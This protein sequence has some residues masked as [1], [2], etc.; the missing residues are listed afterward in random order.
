[1]D[2][3]QRA[4]LAKVATVPWPRNE[5]SP[6]A[7]VKSTSYAENSIAL[8]A[9]QAMGAQEALLANTQG[10]LCEGTSSNVFLVLNGA[11]CTPPLSS[12]CLAGVTRH[13]VLQ[14]AQE[15]GLTVQQ[16]PLP[17]Q[18]IYLASEAFL[19]STYREVQAIA[20][21]DAQVLPQA[22]GPVTQALQAAFHKLCT[23]HD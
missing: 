20:Q 10:D 19:T 8:A 3:P 2:L 6:L 1:M 23:A 22:P 15:M 7:E 14:L 21:V 11:L 16:E 17:F 18:S 4:A 12:G 9:A 5:R 13:F